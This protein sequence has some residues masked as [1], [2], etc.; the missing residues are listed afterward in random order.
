MKFG[1][2]GGIG[3]ASTLDYYDGLTKKYYD[4]TGECAPLVIDSIDMYAMTGLLSKGDNEGVTRLILSSLEN[5]SA[6]G[7]TAA[8]MASNTPHIV[9][10]ELVKRSPLPLL[11]IVDETCKYIEKMGFRCAL[12]LG[13]EFTMKSGLY[14]APLEKYGIKAVTPNEKDMALVHSF[15]FPKLEN[16]IVDE[17]DKKKMVATA[18]RYIAE[19]KADCA[20]L[21]CT[22]IPLM[23]HE[24]DFTVP[25]VNTA[26]VH[27][28]AI[29]EFMI[30]NR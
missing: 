26:G 13:T 3:P 9:F 14:S 24:G 30:K 20:V 29:A 23:I 27:I 21:G 10:D 7:A 28:D 1:I 19:Q 17:E 18:E 22:E 2:V 8:A 11:S 4:A 16:G 25:T 6:A 15:I 12:I 5:L